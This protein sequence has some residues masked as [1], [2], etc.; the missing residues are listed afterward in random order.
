MHQRTAGWSEVVL[1][2][3]RSD[4]CFVSLPS[5][6]LNQRICN[7]VVHSSCKVMA[8]QVTGSRASVVCDGSRRTSVVCDGSS[9]P[10]IASLVR[11]CI[12]GAHSSTDTAAEVA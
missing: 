5:V 11:Q 3:V 4:T 12:A 9:L 2:A 1:L 6:A 8:M 7:H 10:C